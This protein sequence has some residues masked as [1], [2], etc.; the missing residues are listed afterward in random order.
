MK[1]NLERL[2]LEQADNQLLK[3]ELEIT[4]KKLQNDF[5]KIKQKLRLCQSK[6]VKQC[7]TRSTRFKNLYKKIT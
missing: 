6:K 2:L 3:R 1:N 7:K 4:L 5:K